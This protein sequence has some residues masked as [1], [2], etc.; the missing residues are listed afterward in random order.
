[1]EHISSGA[2]YLCPNLTDVTIDPENKI[3]YMKGNCIIERETKTL[4]RGITNSVIPTDG[5]V[6]IIGYNAFT[7]CDIVEAFIPNCIKEVQS[8]VFGYCTKLRK[9]TLPKGLTKI[10]TALFYGCE[11]LEEIEIPDGVTEIHWLAFNECK[12]LKRIVIPQGV[13]ELVETFANCTALEEV[14]LHDNIEGID[15][16]FWGCTSLKK[17]TLGSKLNYISYA[18][19]DCSSLKEIEL[20]GAPEIIGANA[21]SGCSSLETVIIREGVIGIESLVFEGCSSLKKIVLPASL[22]YI[23]YD[24]FKGA[25]VS[26]EEIV[27]AEGNE[28]FVLVDGCLI[29]KE[30]G[31]LVL[32]CAD[33]KIPED[34]SVKVIGAGVFS[35]H[36][37]TEVKLPASITTI[38]NYAFYG[39]PS[40]KT[41]EVP[42]G[43][44]IIGYYAFESCTALESIRIP[45]SITQ[46]GDY[47]FAKC[48]V[49]KDVSFAPRSTD[50]DLG[51]WIFYECTALVSFTFPEGVTETG[52][53]MFYKCSSLEHVVLPQTL[54]VL[55]Q[56]FAVC[57]NLKEISIPASVTHIRSSAFLSVK[58][59]EVLH[60]EG[61]MAQWNKISKP[62]SYGSKWYSG[63]NIKIVRCSDGEIS[64][65]SLE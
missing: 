59:I 24:A 51:S 48:T 50:I 40:L 26:L 64:L 39:C 43:V 1:M 42:E 33:A 53:Y 63:S 37:I 45:S 5:S 38:G 65:A 27:L 20:L 14:V 56:S 3:F 16:A 9:V 8:G 4:V 60:F 55:R 46:I 57:E 17:V 10:E 6:E 28:K 54:K 30:S 18:F 21:F 22:E 49:L 44:T 62:T 32:K 7:G 41:A 61:T 31:T 13:V 35:G 2:F 11:S 47:A 23:S 52:S 58:H 36:D 12:S 15:A 34:G 25:S 19:V 29:E